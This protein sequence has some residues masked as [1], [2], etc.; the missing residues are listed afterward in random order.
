LRRPGQIALLRFPQV[1][2][3]AGKPRPVLLIVQLPGRFED[4]LVCMLSTQLH[5]ALPGFDEVL[6]ESQADFAE[7]GLKVPSLIRITRLAVVSAEAMTGTTGSISSERLMRIK[8]IL[9]DW[10]IQS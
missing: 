3:S 8:K 10:I 4:W 1:D 6:D 7:S 5:Q 9:S 2:L